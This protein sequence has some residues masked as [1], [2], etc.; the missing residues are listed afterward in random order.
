[1]FGD[2]ATD[3]RHFTA[4][5]VKHNTAQNAQTADAHTVKLMNPMAYL[6]D[7][8]T[9][10]ARHWRIRHGAKDSDT[11]FA[12]P[13]ILATKLANQGKDV[14][15]AMPWGQGHGGDYDLDELFAWVDGIA[16]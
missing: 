14:D 2:N 6:D 8:T 12:I 16:K 15:Y 5:G 3:N 7:N 9:S 11:G 1:M 13:V 4:F 10:T